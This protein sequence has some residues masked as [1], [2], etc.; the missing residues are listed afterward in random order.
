VVKVARDPN[1]P[2]DVDDIGGAGT[3]A[4]DNLGAFNVATRAV[5]GSFETVN[6]NPSSRH[7]RRLTARLRNS[8]NRVCSDP[9]IKIPSAGRTHTI[10]RWLSL[11]FPGKACGRRPRGRSARSSAKRMAHGISGIIATSWLVRGDQKMGG[12]YR[13]GSVRFETLSGSRGNPSASQ[14]RIAERSQLAGDV[15]EPN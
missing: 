3:I 14:D 15:G 4:I 8:I 9:G 13:L 12:G 11:C 6:P 1:A 5:P 7:S 2:D 10:R